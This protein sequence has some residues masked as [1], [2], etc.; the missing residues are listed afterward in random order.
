MRNKMILM[1][2]VVA[3]IAVSA[4]PAQAVV[5]PNVV[6]SSF[7]IKEGAASVGKDFTL[8]LVL[9]NV[10]PSACAMAISTSIEAAPP[11]IMNGVSTVSAGDLCMNSTK[12][13]NIPM[14]IDPSATGGTYQLTIINNYETVMLAQFSST[15]TINIFVQGTPDLNANV[16]SSKPIDIYTGDTA[17]LTVNIENTGN[18]K[19][20]SVNAKLS[21]DSPLDVKWSDSFMTLG[22]LEAK[23]SKTA[24]FSV[25]VPKDAKAL[26]YPMQLTVQYLDEN[27][28]MKTKTFAFTLNVNKK[29]MF[30]ASDVGSSALFANSNLKVIKLSLKNTGTD[31][32]RNI[33]AKI[34]PQYPFSTDGSVRYI[35]A[36]EPG[37]S[38]PVDFVVNVDKDATVGTYGLDMI[39]DFEDAQGKDFQDTTPVSLTV[40]SKSIFRAVFLEY[41]YLWVIAILIAFNVIMRKRKASKKK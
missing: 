26:S 11:F 12:E 34:Q 8:S 31:I 28:A 36:L 14:R 18:F 1:I 4:F 25:E 13:I 30:E 6:V 39:I 15:N 21:A 7:S 33:K 29:A 19:A 9:T 35:D 32:A 40:E 37:K 41:W 17:T 22:T 27:L 20:Q 10:E 23:Q 2:M 5:H 38:M 24:D 16:I 3:L